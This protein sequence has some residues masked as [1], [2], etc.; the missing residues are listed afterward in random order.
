MRFY[1][2]CEG[3][4]K[5][6]K[7]IHKACS[8]EQSKHVIQ[9]RDFSGHNFCTDTATIQRDGRKLCVFLICHDSWDSGQMRISANRSVAML[10]FWTFK[11]F[12]SFFLSFLKTGSLHMASFLC[13][14]K[15]FGRGQ[16]GMARLLQDQVI[17][18]GKYDIRAVSKYL[19][20]K[21]FLHGDEITLVRAIWFSHK[22]VL[23]IWDS[24]F[25]GQRS[26]LRGYTDH[27][28][29]W[30]GLFHWCFQLFCVF[31][32]RSTARCSDS[33]V[34][35]SI[36]TFLFHIRKFWAQNARTSSRMWSE[37]VSDCGLT[38]THWPIKSWSKRKS[39]S[40]FCPTV[41]CTPQKGTILG[42]QWWSF[43]GFS[44]ADTLSHKKKIPERERHK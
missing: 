3:S 18:I 7:Y 13:R 16:R 44:A 9:K 20:N 25:G 42:C 35:S 6:P 28:W 22:M 12:L 39:N 24:G 10:W 26:K 34:R 11:H 33:C 40:L 27:T 29:A 5:Q 2:C 31:L 17:E 4:K 32:F 43:S 1:G 23:W 36:Q 21:Q 41:S 30:V 8:H 19:G 38:G 14:C 15:V 37:S